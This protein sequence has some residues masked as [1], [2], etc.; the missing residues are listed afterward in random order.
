MD[1]DFIE[2]LEFS[3]STTRLH[4]YGTAEDDAE[5]KLHRYFWNIELSQAFYPLL[6]AF[7]VSLRNAIHQTVTTAKGTDRWFEIDGFLGEQQTAKVAEIVE[8]LHIQ[9]K[10]ATADR[11]VS[12]LMFG[13]WTSLLNRPYEE[14]LWHTGTPIALVKVFPHFPKHKRTR[15]AVY[16]RVQLANTIR[17]RIF[18]FE[19]IWNRPNLMEE[20][21]H[22]IEALGWISPDMA[23]MVRFYDRFNIIYSQ[24]Y[25]FNRSELKAFLGH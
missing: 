2:R 3:L 15:K 18:H 9:N 6:H 7:E 14:S 1:E 12:R 19:P 23:Q 17:N 20:Y 16:G 13:F 22:I 5:T 21:G 4:S 10:E 24:G 8:S 25:V 11:I